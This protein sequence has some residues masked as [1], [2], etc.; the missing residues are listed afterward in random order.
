MEYKLV[1]PLGGDGTRRDGDLGMLLVEDRVGIDGGRT[2]NGV[3]LTPRHL[4]EEL[5]AYLLQ[6]ILQLHTDARRLGRLTQIVFRQPGSNLFA[7]LRG[8]LRKMF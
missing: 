3:C 6:D 2:T 7:S 5:K 1:W 8:I 4:P